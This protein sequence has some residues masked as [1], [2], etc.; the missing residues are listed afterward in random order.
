MSAVGKLDWQGTQLSEV[1]ILAMVAMAYGSADGEAKGLIRR[2]G[3]DRE[4]STPRHAALT[5]AI[6]ELLCQRL[7]QTA[8]RG[9]VR[10]AARKDILRTAVIAHYDR[11]TI[12][13][14]KH[15]ASMATLA[16]ASVGAPDFG[17]G[18]GTRPRSR[19]PARSGT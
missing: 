18:G 17:K 1:I 16:R 15:A 19:L 12:T 13:A 5:D 3:R 2:S 8:C 14:S 7:D 4:P 10:G 9:S 6:G 11:H